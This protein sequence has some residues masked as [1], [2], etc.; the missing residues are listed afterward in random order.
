ML[1][2]SRFFPILFFLTN[3]VEAQTITIGK[4]VW[5]TKN[6]NVDK[7]RNGDPIPEVKNKDEWEKAGKNKQP[8]WC[9]YNNDVSNGVKY[10]KLY[11]WYAVND[12]RGLAPKGW[13]IPNDT[14]WIT[15]V[16]SLG[17]EFLAGKKMKAKNGWLDKGSGTDESGFTGLPGGKRTSKGGFTQLGKWGFWWTSTQ[18]A[19]EKAWFRYL[20]FSFDIIPRLIY[21]KDNGLSV[22]CI[23]D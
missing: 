6:L 2:L 15:L 12:P 10:G 19:P 17:G 7:F 13:H 3:F 23:K 21:V 9:Y 11:N 4:Q 1:K 16:T 5:M 18:T 14:E 20:I 8:A 22:R